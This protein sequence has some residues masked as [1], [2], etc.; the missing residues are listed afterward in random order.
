MGTLAATGPSDFRASIPWLPTYRVKGVLFGESAQAIDDPECLSFCTGRLHHY[1]H[2][3]LNFWI[4]LAN[5]GLV[6]LSDD[7]ILGLRAVTP[8]LAEARI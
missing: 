7:T 1:P 8:L 6:V 2:W 4:Q 3:T 5:I